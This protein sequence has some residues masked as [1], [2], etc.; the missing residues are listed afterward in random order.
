VYGGWRVKPESELYQQAEKLGYVFC[1]NGY[2][3]RSGGESGIMS[4]V[5]KGAARAN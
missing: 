5:S 1:H 4:A 3:V 2:T